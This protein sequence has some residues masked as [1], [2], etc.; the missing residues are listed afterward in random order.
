VPL[1]AEGMDDHADAPNR[2]RRFMRRTS[3][4][5]W[6]D[7]APNPWGSTTEA[8]GR[9]WGRSEKENGG[10]SDGTRQDYARGRRERIRKRNLA[11]GM[12]RSPENGR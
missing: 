9:G 4:W 1:P 2:V 11:K 12:F 10:D 8:L 7:S 6:V 5:R 3:V